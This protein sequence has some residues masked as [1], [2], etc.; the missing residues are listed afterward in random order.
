MTGKEGRT[1]GW[2][3]GARAFWTP[4]RIKTVAIILVGTVGAISVVAAHG[5]GGASQAQ[6]VTLAAVILVGA[7]AQAAPGGSDSGGART[8]QVILWM[9]AALALVNVAVA[10]IDLDRWAWQ[11]PN[12]L[13][14]RNPIGIDFRATYAAAQQFSIAPTGWPPFT[15]VLSTPYLLLGPNAAYVVHVGIL[16]ALN[17]A[18]L[19][20]AAAVL[21]SHDADGHPLCGPAVAHVGLLAP[22]FAVWLFVS[23]G[24]L[25]S[26]E[27][28]NYDAFAAFLAMLGLWSLV[29]RP[30]GVWLPVIAFSAAASIKVYPALLMLLVIW[31]FGRKSILPLIAC[32]VVLALSAGPDNLVN[33]LSSVTRMMAA[34]YFSAGNSSAK[35]FSAFVGESYQLHVPVNLLIAIP[36]VLFLLTAW[37]VWRRDDHAA[38][39]LML[40]GMVPV[41]FVVPSISNDYKLVLFAGPAVLL[42]G[43]LMRHIGRGSAEPWWMLLVLLLALFFIAT[44]P[45][46]VWPV[47]L[48]NKYPWILLLQVVVAWMAWRLP[49][50]MVPGS[51][52]LPAEPEPSPASG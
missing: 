48:S 42:A 27:R 40:C 11:A 46:L 50:S 52:S 13:P 1:S 2:A 32:N 10:W 36:V 23:D 9:V 5:F 29:R 20:L 18:A 16:V 24:F 12:Y 15:V 14:S 22:M 43:L 7:G 26:V 19:G 41:M 33:F 45:G 38:T 37:R 30:A 21:R 44:P 35:S 4:T 6:L 49:A 51:R 34:E 25:F 8:I 47:I 39:T 31:R 28:G 3:A 17:L